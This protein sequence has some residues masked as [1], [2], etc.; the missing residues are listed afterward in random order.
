MEPA[1]PP[2]ATPPEKPKETAKETA[3]ESDTREALCLMVK[4]AAQG[5]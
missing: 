4:S 1:T 3:R 2:D 5:G